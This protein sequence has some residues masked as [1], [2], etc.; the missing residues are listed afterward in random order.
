MFFNRKIRIFN[1]LYP[2][3]F[4]LRLTGQLIANKKYNKFYLIFY[5]FKTIIDL[6]CIYNL[7]KFEKLVSFLDHVFNDVYFA[8]A[9]LSL[10]VVYINY[11]IY[12]KILKLLLKLNQL[13]LKLCT[14]L[15]LN[16]NHRKYKKIFKILLILW[17]LRYLFHIFYSYYKNQLEFFEFVRQINVIW[18]IGNDIQILSYIFIIQIYFLNL[19]YYLIHN[20]YIKLKYIK[21]SCKYYCKLC[22]KFDQLLQLYG[23]TLLLHMFLNSAHVAIM[24]FR[25]I[26]GKFKINLHTIWSCEPF[27]LVLLVVY[28]FQSIQTKVIK[29]KQIFFN[30]IF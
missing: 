25:E 24:F 16:F 19:N 20:N 1:T 11:F 4:S 7:F 6:Y 14:N 3:H 9:S 26:T 8:F 22:K 10:A 28:A 12:N 29:K 5:I 15:N 17:I 2:I 23:V 30:I 27:A 13:E 21:Y 18:L